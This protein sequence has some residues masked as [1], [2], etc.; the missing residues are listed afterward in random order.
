VECEIAVG[1]LADWLEGCGVTVLDRAPGFWKGGGRCGACRSALVSTPEGVALNAG[2]VLWRCR[3]PA[4]S[5]HERRNWFVR[6]VAADEPAVAP[7]CADII[8]EARRPGK[9]GQNVNKA[10][11]GVRVVDSLTGFTAS[12]VTARTQ[13]GNRRLALERLQGKIRASNEDR[14]KS[15][16]EGRWTTHNGIERGNPVAVFQGLDFSPAEGQLLLPAS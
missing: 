10:E 15:I 13:L 2:A 1:T 6:V 14:E 16:A 12:S 5:G 11:T 4:R 7:P 9:G 8:P 3:S